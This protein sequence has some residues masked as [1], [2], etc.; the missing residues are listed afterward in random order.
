MVGRMVRPSLGDAARNRT[1]S[2]KVSRTEE[3]VLEARYGTVH[4]GLRVALDALLAQQ[5]APKKRKKSPGEAAIAAAVETPV[6]PAGVVAPCRI[7][8]DFKVIKR[9]AEKGVDWTTRRCGVCGFEISRP[10]RG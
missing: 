1:G 10:D 8:S 9:W 5:P 6:V 4:S 3:R 2:T 7:H